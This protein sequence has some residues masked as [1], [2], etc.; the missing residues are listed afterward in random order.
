MSSLTA[1]LARIGVVILGVSHATRTYF[2]Y[3]QPDQETVEAGGISREIRLKTNAEGEANESATA[4]WANKIAKETINQER[5]RAYRRILDAIVRLNR[6]VVEMNA[7]QLR[8]QADIMV[9]DGD[10]ELD[11]VYANVNQTYQSNFHVISPEVREAVS[12]YVDYLVTYH[13]EGAQAGELLQRSGTV[14]EMMRQDFGL[15]SL[16]EEKSEPVSGSP[17]DFKHG[18]NE[19]SQSE[20]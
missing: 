10:S 15:R 1:I 18:E 5:L 17:Y 19:S 11:D 4:N 8:E 7:E 12:E 16:F 9:H 3:L 14:A 2:D 20:E 13:D 6:A